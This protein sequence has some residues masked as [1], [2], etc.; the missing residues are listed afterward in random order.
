MADVPKPGLDEL[1]AAALQQE[2]A[3]REEFLHQACAGDDSLLADLRSLLAEYLA[4]PPTSSRE[5]LADGD[6]LNSRYR[7]E[8]KIGQGGFGAVFLA[9]DLQLHGKP[10]VV[11]MLLDPLAGDWSR[12]MFREECEALA[13][14]NHPSVVQV[15]DNGATA[16]GQPFLVMQF[17]EGVTLRD[18]I[19]RQPMQ[20]DRVARIVE[21]LGDA[22]AAV[23]A[24]GVCH[25]D[26]KPENI[27]LC[28][29]GGG[30]EMPVIIDFGI[31]RLARPGQPAVTANI[32]G[33]YA[34]M[35]PERLRG[36]SGPA[37]DI[38][39][40]GVI[41]CEMLTGKLPNPPSLQPSISRPDLPPAAEAEILR[42]LAADSDSRPTAA[43]F[44]TAV[45]AALRQPAP[46]SPTPT[47]LPAV[48][49]THGRLRFL[50]L[51]V[52][53]TALTLLLRW[54]L[55]TSPVTQDRP[56]STRE[57]LFAFA[58]FLALWAL[59]R[60]LVRFRTGRR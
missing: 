31:A 27:L 7:I 3:R 4:A 16:A 52:P 10:V 15:L 20:L 40:L 56:L 45:A 54:Y 59:L 33:S 22:L 58:A 34:Y 32:A 51:L 21:Q 42:A 39:S 44:S 11:K 50:T 30:K 24:Q 25:R 8:H 47:P 29:L 37:S 13:R 60:W 49:T 17:V 5:P 41:A 48:A 2:P 55:N 43:H 18:A 46:P 36:E 35:S 57:T 53:P 23:H 1:F 14:I 28:D 9:R 12:R 19:L 26:L 6:C 38:F